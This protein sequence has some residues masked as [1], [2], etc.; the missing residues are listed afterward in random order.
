MQELDLERDGDPLN[1]YEILPLGSMP[2]SSRLTGLERWGSGVPLA[3]AVDE[4][5]ETISTMSNMRPERMARRDI[6]E[7]DYW[8]TKVA[9]IVRRLEEIAGGAVQ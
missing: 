3:D 6:R 5:V 1:L 4:W 2:A 8:D 7:D 9:G